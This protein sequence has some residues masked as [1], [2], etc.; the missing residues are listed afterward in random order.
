M[1]EADLAAVAIDCSDDP[2]ELARWWQGLVGGEVVVDRDGDAE[3]HADGWPRLDFLRVPDDKTVKNRLHLDL[4]A[5]D[6]DAAAA[7]ARARRDEGR[8]RLRR[9][10]VARCCA[11]LRATSSAS[12]GREGAGV[13]PPSFSED[14]HA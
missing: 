5:R 3:P 10:P 7:A 9:R 2:A 4:R 11:T 8:R 13:R 1:I 12:C 6:H 14:Q